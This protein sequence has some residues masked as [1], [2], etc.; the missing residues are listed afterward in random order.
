[1]RLGRLFRRGGPD[2]EAS[3]EPARTNFGGGLF[4]WFRRSKLDESDW[5]ALE[6]ILLQADMGPAL[7]LTIVEAL[8]EAARSQGL[9]DAAALRDHLRR[10]LVEVL[11][12]PNQLFAS[13]PAPQVVLM[14]GVNGVG[15][16]TTIAK[17]ANLLK[18]SGFSVTLA[19][20][21]T[22]RAG[23]IDQLKIWGERVDVPVIAH[24]PG[25]DA[26]AVLYDA[27]D[28][29]KARG[30][31]YVIAD[32]AGRQHTN[33][34]LM[35]ELVKMRRVAERQVAGA[36]HETLLVLDAMTGQN[37]I[38]QAKAFLEAVKISGIVMTKLDG[39]AKGGV[40]FAVTRELGVP[41]KFV[42]TGETLEAFAAFDP[43]SYVAALLGDTTAPDENEEP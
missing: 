18:S 19:A 12:G 28:A 39:S 40:A 32:S 7:T 5:D 41:I 43:E 38:R 23:A 26:A 34:N 16:T 21:D 31:D 27:L 33:V 22:F 20:G 4:R 13:G 29:A 9:Q 6:E 8:R 42:G 37:G 2:I 35:N 3:I 36:P 17:L 10:Q 1:M 30:T 24:Q 14:V 15:K 25:S 11:G